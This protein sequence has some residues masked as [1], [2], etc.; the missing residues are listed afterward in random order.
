M[1]YEPRSCACG[2]SGGHYHDDGLNAEF[3]GPAL[4][5]GF[6]NY[7]LTKALSHQPPKSATRGENFEA[8]VIQKQCPTFKKVRVPSKK[9]TKTSR[10]ARPA[11]V[12][13]RSKV[14]V[15]VSPEPV[16]YV[17]EVRGECADYLEDLV[18]RHRGKLDWDADYELFL[19]GQDAETLLSLA[20][21]INFRMG[22]RE[23][24]LGHGKHT[25]WVLTPL[26]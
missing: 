3:Y 2:K 9:P 20:A 25:G 22:G 26:L 6:N 11:P 15:E 23:W 8:F 21:P 18:S 13:K 24:V 10:A 16:P 19:N 4:P 1:C 5:L 14:S 17:I 7:S 12:D